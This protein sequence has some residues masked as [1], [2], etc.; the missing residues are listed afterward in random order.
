MPENLLLRTL[1]ANEGNHVAFESIYHLKR[2]YKAWRETHD[3]IHIVAG[4]YSYFLLWSW[5]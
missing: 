4:T 2:W 1:D 3:D 5:V